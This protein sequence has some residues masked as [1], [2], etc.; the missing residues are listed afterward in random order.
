MTGVRG[1]LRSSMC[2]TC[3]SSFLGIGQRLCGAREHALPQLAEER[4][5]AERYTA[6]IPEETVAEY[7]KH[8][9]AVSKRNADRVTAFLTP[10]VTRAA[11]RRLRI[12]AALTLL[13][14]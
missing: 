14:C 10:R 12:G 5:R 13:H 6:A 4:R 1:V 3:R 11:M 9:P 7:A 2:S 8:R